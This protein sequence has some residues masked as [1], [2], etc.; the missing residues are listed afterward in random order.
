MLR[1]E[2]GVT[3]LKIAEYIE[4]PE[5]VH[6]SNVYSWVNKVPIDGNTNEFQ[7]IFVAHYTTLLPDNLLDTTMTA[8]KGSNYLHDDYS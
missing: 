7:Y 4:N 5:S 3:V 8:N 1:T 6:W 2:S